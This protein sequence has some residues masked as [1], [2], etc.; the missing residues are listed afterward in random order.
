LQLLNTRAGG[1]DWSLSPRPLGW[2]SS[3]A[4]LARHHLGQALAQ[5]SVALLAH[6]LRQG[7]LHI[8]LQR[9]QVLARAARVRKEALAEAQRAQ[10]GACARAARAA[11]AR[12]QPL[13]QDRLQ[14]G[15]R[16]LARAL[17]RV[18]V[19]CLAHIYCQVLRASSHVMNSRLCLTLSVSE[20]GNQ[21]LPLP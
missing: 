14:L 9:G 17:R 3:A 18:C 19:L 4:A 20:A 16:S 7:S 6:R 15:R 1:R 10:Q 13:N 2:E 8:C 5:L 21:T 11:G 12:A